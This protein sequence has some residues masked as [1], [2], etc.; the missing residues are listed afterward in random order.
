MDTLSV[1]VHVSEQPPKH[2]V[3]S[4]NV[5]ES[6]ENKRNFLLDIIRSDG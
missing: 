4:G 6:D 2:I 5:A 1:F 3:E